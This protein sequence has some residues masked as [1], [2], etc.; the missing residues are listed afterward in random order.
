MEGRGA[1]QTNLPR[2]PHRF[3]DTP[4]S[5]KSEEIRKVRHTAG[6]SAL[7]GL[8]SYVRK[9]SG[10]KV[11]ALNTLQTFDGGGVYR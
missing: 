3:L 11:S 7:I 6:L 9:K 10:P 5:L 2:F 4:V 1:D 8:A